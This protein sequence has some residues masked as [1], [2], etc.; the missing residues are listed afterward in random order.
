MNRRRSVTPKP[1]V[2]TE[3]AKK[4]IDEAAH[5]GPPGIV[6]IEDA[7]RLADDDARKA[8]LRVA[9]WR[10]ELVVAIAAKKRLKQELTR[11][12]NKF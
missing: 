2:G 11:Q 7:M 3:R 6:T 1:R 4:Y 10:R 8:E 5:G 12:L 9:E